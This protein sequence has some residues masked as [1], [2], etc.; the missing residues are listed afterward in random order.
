MGLNGKIS[1]VIWQK[2]HHTSPIVIFFSVFYAHVFFR[3]NV[4]LQSLNC[5]SEAVTG[6]EAEAEAKREAKMDTEVVA[7]AENKVE[8]KAEVKAKEEV[9]AEAEVKVEME[10][11][12]KAEVK[13]EAKAETELGG[14]TTWIST[15][16][17]LR[18]AKKKELFFSGYM[19]LYC[20]DYGLAHKHCFG[21]L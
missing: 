1:S 6:A 14:E 19:V 4:P 5:K 3:L 18:I 12:A 8:E 15:S 21:S 13:V 10:A 20:D 9:E 11:E 17:K 7:E 16:S 2:S